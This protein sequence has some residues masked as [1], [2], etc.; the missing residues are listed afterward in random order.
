MSD[1]FKKWVCDK[2]GDKYFPSNGTE[3]I[4]FEGKY[5]NICKKDPMSRDLNAKGQCSILNNALA[6]GKQPKQWIY[7]KNLKPTCTSFVHYQEKRIVKK[8]PKK[9]ELL[10]FKI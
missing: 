1:D 5:C 4:W 7:D 6:L 3:G 2:A 9:D 10:F 8:K